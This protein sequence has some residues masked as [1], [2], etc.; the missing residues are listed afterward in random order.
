MQDIFVGVSPYDGYF[1]LGEQ[2]DF[3]PK[4]FLT[5]GDILLPL[6]I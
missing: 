3:M 2:F 1:I 6:G 5:W 4:L